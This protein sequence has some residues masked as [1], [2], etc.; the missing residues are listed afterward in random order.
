MATVQGVKLKKG[1]TVVFPITHINAV[2][3]ESGQNLTTVLS[4]K[5]NSSHDHAIS[6]ITN[7]QNTLNGKA[8]SSHTHS[9]API[10]VYKTV[11]TATEREQI[12]GEWCWVARIPSLSVGQIAFVSI[13]ALCENKSAGH[14]WSEGDYG[15]VKTQSG[16]TC[17]VMAFHYAQFNQYAGNTAIVSELETSNKYF[18]YQC[19]VCRIS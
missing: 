13:N 15:A 12:N 3:N 5:A 7:L 4:G 1:N 11:T 10:P 16:Q 18:S 2:K 17:A 19:L 9:Y 8:N 14:Y 6:D